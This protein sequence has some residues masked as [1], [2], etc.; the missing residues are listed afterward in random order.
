MVVTNLVGNKIAG[1]IVAYEG[2]DLTALGKVGC[3]DDPWHENVPRHL[4]FPVSAGH[5]YYIQVG[6]DG[7][8]ASGVFNF[9]LTAPRS[10]VTLYASKTS[11]RHGTSV[12]LSGTV[13]PSRPGATVIIQR[14]VNGVWR[15]F[16]TVRLSSASAYRYVW[17]PR[18]AGTFVFRA[19]IGARANPSVLGGTSATRKVVVR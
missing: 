3:A 11:V 2:T 1:I 19:T 18:A 7:W 15:T 5:T 17:T 13:R 10:V 16:T 4:A 14:K 6:A 12:T 9:T 8:A